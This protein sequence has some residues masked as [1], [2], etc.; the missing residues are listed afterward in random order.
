VRTL[1]LLMLLSVLNHS[2][3]AGTRVAVSLY[4]IRLGESPFTVGTLMALYSLL[5]MLFAV[6]I[7]RLTDRFGV[8]APMLAGSAILAA[9]ALI[10]FLRPGIGGL[11]VAS[12]LIGSSFM[13]YHV[14][15]QNVVGYIGRPEDRAANFSVAALGFSISGFSGPMLAGF[16]IDGFGYATTFLVLAALPLVPALVLGLDKLPLPKLPGHGAPPGKERRLADLFRHRELRRLFVVSGLLAMAWD[17]FN[18][19]VPIYGSR[20]QL[21]ASTIGVVLGAFSVATFVVRLFLPAISRRLSAWPLLVV[22]LVIAGTSFVLFPVFRTATPLMML[23]FF[24]GL[25]LGMSQ[26]MVMSLMH[27]ATPPGRVGEAVGV[28]MTLVNMSQTGM[29][30]LFGALGSALGMAPV[31]WAT[32]LLLLAGGFV[33]KRHHDRRAKR[34]A[35]ESSVP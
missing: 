23:A 20:I 2:T 27:N 13:L 25:G 28:R 12:I 31:F 10:P 14:A 19:A 26:P 15:A 17:L 18:F 33:A 34:E 4:A 3:F 1:Y 35:V 11:Y 7:G 30:L 21:S 8:R 16:G 29:P 32:A 24:L 22:S 6:S 9:S 5:P